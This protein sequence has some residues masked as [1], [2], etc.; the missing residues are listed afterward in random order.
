VAVKP[1]QKLFHDLK[2]QL[3]KANKT[4]HLVRVEN[5]IGQGTPDLN[6]CYDGVEF[7]LELKA[8]DGRIPRLSKYQ[9]AW[10][11]R[12]YKSG[13][14]SFILQRTLKQEHLKLFEG[15]GTRDLG[16][17]SPV[18]ELPL[19]VP[20]SRSDFPLPVSRLPFVEVFDYIKHN[21]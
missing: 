16:T 21:Y 9:I 18:F 4:I 13:G 10:H 20:A 11:Y 5:L 8:D 15:S 2:K 14:R 6:C 1:E 3:E 17:W 19:P 12:R 7:W